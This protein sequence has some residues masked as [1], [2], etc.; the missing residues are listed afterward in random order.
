VTVVSIFAWLCGRMTLNWRSGLQ[1]GL[2][3]DVDAFRGWEF[4]ASIVIWAQWIVCA[5]GIILA[6]VVK[7]A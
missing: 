2:Y 1:R 5:A 6:L 4:V 7:R 3:T